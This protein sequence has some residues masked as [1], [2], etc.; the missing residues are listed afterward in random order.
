M[1]PHRL[2]FPSFPSLLCVFHWY[3]EDQWMN[4]LVRA[5]RAQFWPNNSSSTW[6]VCLGTQWGSSGGNVGLTGTPGSHS[7]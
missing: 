2:N 4:E 7:I 1:W 6:G 5:A 3:V